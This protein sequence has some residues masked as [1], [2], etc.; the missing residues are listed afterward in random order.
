M[1]VFEITFRYFQDSKLKDEW[2]D[3][4]TNPIIYHD[5]KLAIQTK[6]YKK[7]KYIADNDNIENQFTVAK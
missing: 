5:Y 7:L 2:W 6:I 4:K 1:T 3:R